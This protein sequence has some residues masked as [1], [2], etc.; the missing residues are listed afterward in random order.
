[1]LLERDGILV[2]DIVEE[3]DIRP[4]SASELVA[5]LEKRGFVRTETD[6]Q[7]K[8]AKRVYVTEKTHE[9]ADRIKTSHS[10]AAAEILAA[11]SADEQEQLL[12]LLRKITV[13]LE[14]RAEK[15]PEDSA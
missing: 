5:K 12:T 13:S 14:Q 7:D 2:K 3:L 1:L 11:L 4:S 10:E 6:S 15:H 9:F 8:R